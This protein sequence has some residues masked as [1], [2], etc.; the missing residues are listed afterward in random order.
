MH[1]LKL[2]PKIYFLFSQFF[3][4]MDNFDFVAV[5]KSDNPTLDA[6]AI[7]VMDKIEDSWIPFEQQCLQ[8]RSN[9]CYTC[10]NIHVVS[11]NGS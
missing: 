3:Y 6:N 5:V 10:Y 11:Q 2:K 1:K 8:N 7:T 9:I 4:D